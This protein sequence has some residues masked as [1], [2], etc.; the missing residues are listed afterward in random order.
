MN[1]TVEFL[2][3]DSVQKFVA[4]LNDLSRQLRYIPSSDFFEINKNI[5]LCLRL[6]ELFCSLIFGS[7]LIIFGF[8][9][10]AN[11]MIF[12][13]A[14]RK[15]WAATIPFYGDYVMFDIAT[16][17]GFLGIIYALL[18]FSCLFI[19]VFSLL[20]GFDMLASGISVI[21]VNLILVAFM[22]FKLEKKFGH[23]IGFCIGLLLLPIIFYPI[24]GFGKSEYKSEN[25]IKSKKDVV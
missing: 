17:K 2:T 14:K 22:E 10:I 5:N 8:L 15:S 18:K 12:L 4:V 6:I 13:K 3:Q 24:L 1:G 21:C 19:P 23:G 25:E 20:V 7:G 16:G 9:V 11:A